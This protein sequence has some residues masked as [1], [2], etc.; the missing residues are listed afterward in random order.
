MGLVSVMNTPPVVFCPRCQEVYAFE[1][2]KWNT[3]NPRMAVN[4][5]S[6]R[7][8]T[9]YICS[10]CGHAEAMADWLKT[11]FAIERRKIG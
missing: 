9:T 6:R 7:D 3:L 2:N 4:S 8:N 1:P 11:S 10:D 5:L